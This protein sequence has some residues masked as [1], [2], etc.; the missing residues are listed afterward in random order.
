MCEGCTAVWPIGAN[1]M[2]RSISMSSH[3][4]KV[5]RRCETYTV[6]RHIKPGGYYEQM[7]NSVVATSEDGTVSPGSVFDRWAKT[8]LAAGE[9]FGKTLDVINLQKQGLIDAGFEQVVEH[10]FKVPMGGWS[11][12]RKLKELG[13]YNRLYWEQGLEGW[14]LYLFTHYLGWKY[15]EI[16]VFIA[17][18]RKT[19]RDKTVHAY[20]EW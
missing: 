18:M 12:D 11:R 19:L 1:S 10:R 4:I 5:S 3:I 9:K 20:H 2:T 17:E 7:E 14:C 15:E 8:S 6:F 16:Q 13:M